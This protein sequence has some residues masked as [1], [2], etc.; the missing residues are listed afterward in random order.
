MTIARINEHS[1]VLLA[2]DGTVDWART[3][4]SMTDTLTYHG[5]HRAVRDARDGL[6][7]WLCQEGVRCHDE[8]CE[9]RELFVAAATV[10]VEY[11]RHSLLRRVEEEVRARVGPELQQLHDEL[12][13]S[14]QFD[15]ALDV[16]ELLEYVVGW[17][18]EAAT[19]N[20]TD[21]SSAEGAGGSG[22]DRAADGA[23]DSGDE[24]GA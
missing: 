19:G 11:A 7:T 20:E 2:D 13:A 3:L 17:Y 23:G 12:M 4:T 24:A 5:Y 18:G 6:H 9:R 15:H 8:A 22:A 1:H 10:A 14:R 16:G 21:G